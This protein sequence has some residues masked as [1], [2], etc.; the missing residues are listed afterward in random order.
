MSLI[1]E[2]AFN[3]N[4]ADQRVAIQQEVTCLIEPALNHV[5]MW[6]LSVGAF[7]SARKICLAKLDL[8]TQV[9][10]TYRRPDIPFN[11]FANATGLPIKQPSA[12]HVASCPRQV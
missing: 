5:G 12:S 11:M 8:G 4:V 3:G 2:T 1:S 7:K 6:C 10:N 9:R